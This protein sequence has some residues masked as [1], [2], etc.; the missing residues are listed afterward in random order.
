MKVL[1]IRGPFPIFAI[2]DILQKLQMPFGPSGAQTIK[3]MQKP[4]NQV[5]WHQLISVSS[6]RSQDVTM[7]TFVIR[8]E[9]RERILLSS[10]LRSGHSPHLGS[11]CGKICWFM[12]PG[13]P[14]SGS[15]GT[16]NERSERSSESRLAVHRMHFQKMTTNFNLLQFRWWKRLVHLI[17]T[18]WRKTPRRNTIFWR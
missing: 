16:N 9:R 2:S 14:M 15:N 6:I 18:I 10:N 17:C 8:T 13:I 12:A 5:I 7:R 4:E 3:P 11:V 1:I